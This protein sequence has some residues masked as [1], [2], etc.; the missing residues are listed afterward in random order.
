MIRPTEFKPHHQENSSANIKINET[1]LNFNWTNAKT[2]PPTRTISKNEEKANKPINSPSKA[3]HKMRHQKTQIYSQN[4]PH[5]SPHFEC[6]NICHG[7]MAAFS[8][9]FVTRE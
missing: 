9:S 5:H 8:F 3:T 2:R 6:S 4:T 1:N 7:S